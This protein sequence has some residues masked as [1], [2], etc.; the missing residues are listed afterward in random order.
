M[1]FEIYKTKTY[2]K[3]YVLSF[4][5][6][7]MYYINPMTFCEVLLYHRLITDRMDFYKRFKTFKFKTQASG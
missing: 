1:D 3:L 6:D 7:G 2:T 4:K 5:V